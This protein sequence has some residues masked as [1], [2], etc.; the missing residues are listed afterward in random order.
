MT[1]HA[2]VS[3]TATETCVA[4][5]QSSPAGEVDFVPGDEGASAYGRVEI[6]WYADRL[7][8][9]ALGAGSASITEA[10]PSGEAGHDVVVE[11]RLPRL[12]E[13]TERMPGA[14]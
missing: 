1:T 2:L 10:Y 8:V 5:V 4:K 14:D 7:R 13:L 11:I 3:R 12:D 9:T 6:A